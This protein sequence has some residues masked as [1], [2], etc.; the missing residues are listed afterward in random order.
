MNRHH[1]N[2]LVAALAIAALSSPPRM[3]VPSEVI[4]LPRITGFIAIGL[5]LALG[6]LGGLSYRLGHEWAQQQP[7]ESLRQHLQEHLPAVQGLYLPHP[8]HLPGRAATRLPA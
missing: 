8:P 5:L 4:L 6:C 7:S 1:L 2:T 3:V